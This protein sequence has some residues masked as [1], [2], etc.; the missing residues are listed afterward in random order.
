LEN[1]D[2][3]ACDAVRCEPV[4]VSGFPVIQGVYRENGLFL[5]ADAG[6]GH[7]KMLKSGQFQANSLKK[8]Q[9]IN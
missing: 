4:W 7:P 6:I 5:A 2:C 3:V 1:P 9:G 8:K